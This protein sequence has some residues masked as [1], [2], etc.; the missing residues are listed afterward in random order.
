MDMSAANKKCDKENIPLAEEEISH[1]RL[2]IM[3]MAIEAADKVR[4]GEYCRLV[5][6]GDHRLSGTQYLWLTGRE[7][8]GDL[9][10]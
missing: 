2:H 9:Q 5:E 10:R 7:S 4:K 1:D 8:L 6:R 3:K